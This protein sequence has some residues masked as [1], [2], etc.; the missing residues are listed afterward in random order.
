MSWIHEHVRGAKAQGYATRVLAR[1][2]LGM[3]AGGAIQGVRVITGTE[4]CSACVALAGKVYDP[5]E[6]P[7][8]PVDNCVTPGGCHCAYAAVMA[9]DVV[10]FEADDRPKGPTYAA[11]LLARFRL[12]IR[13]GGAIGGVRVITAPDSC[14]ACLAM[15]GQVYDPNDAPLIPIDHCVTPGGCRCAYGMVMA[16]DVSRSLGVG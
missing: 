2:R 15:T 16:Y 14:P 5:D 13:A 10:G 11:T 1:Y 12:G 4:S 7:L 8:I 9:Y 3:K 6:A